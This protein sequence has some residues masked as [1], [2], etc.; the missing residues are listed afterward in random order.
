MCLYEPPGKLLVWEAKG[1]NL[2]H[3]QETASGVSA[4]LRGYK[5]IITKSGIMP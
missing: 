4:D 3:D 2:Q 5:N 1:C